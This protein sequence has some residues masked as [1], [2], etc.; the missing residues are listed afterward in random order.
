LA[1]NVLGTDNQ[2]YDWAFTTRPDN[3]YFL[4]VITRH[5]D[6]QTV[7]QDVLKTLTLN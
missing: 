3:K 1:S 2:L 6:D 5:S 4:A 7:G